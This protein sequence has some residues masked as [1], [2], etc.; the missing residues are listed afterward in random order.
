MN[1][2]QKEQHLP[3]RRVRSDNGN[4]RSSQD[5]FNKKKKEAGIDLV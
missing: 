2:R 5:Q 1:K 3:V 4:E